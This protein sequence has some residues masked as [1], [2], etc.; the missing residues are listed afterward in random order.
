[1]VEGQKAAQVGE[2]LLAPERDGRVVVAVHDRAAD[3]Q[4]HHLRQ[5]IHDPMR[6]AGILDQGEVIEQGAQPR[7][8]SEFRQAKIHG[9][10][11]NQPH[12]GFSFQCN[13]KPPL[14]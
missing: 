14:T 6:L 3:R 11:P 8:R 12:Q 9:E 1:M 5:R 4:Q 10:A 13:R 7:R 2:M